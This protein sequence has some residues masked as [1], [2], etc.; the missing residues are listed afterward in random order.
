[1]GCF[2][3][4]KTECEH[5]SIRYKKTLQRPLSEEG[6]HHFDHEQET[7]RLYNAKLN[8][9]Q[10]KQVEFEECSKGKQWAE[11]IQNAYHTQGRNVTAI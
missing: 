10:F 8:L 5:C 11:K 2:Q 9:K 1:M 6:E 4:H 3:V 7:K